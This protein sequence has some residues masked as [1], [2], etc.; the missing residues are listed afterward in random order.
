MR[1]PASPETKKRIQA[2][3]RKLASG[4]VISLE[5]AAEIAGRSR[6]T[7]N[8]WAADGKVSFQRVCGKVYVLREEVLAM[9]KQLDGAA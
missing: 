3:E 5:A 1:G 4:G 9:K 6:R 8:G 2:R 7:V